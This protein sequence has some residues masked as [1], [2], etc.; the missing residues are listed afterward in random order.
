MTEDKEIIEEN[1]ENPEEEENEEIEVV[2]PEPN[3]VEMPA[4]EYKEQPEYLKNFANFYIA[5]FEEVD[6]EI[7]DS[8]D[9]NHNVAEINRY[10]I[11]NESFSRK[12]LIKH[13]LQVHSDRFEN[14]LTNIKSETGIDPEELKTYADWNKWYVDC[15]NKIIETLS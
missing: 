10:I 8:F 9:D 5:R 1:N 6:L 3:R 7:M 11:N 15:R 12:D 2:I 13:V 4:T 14:L